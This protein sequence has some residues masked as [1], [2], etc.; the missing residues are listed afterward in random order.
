MPVDIIKIDGSFVRECTD[1][2][3]AAAFLAAIVELTHSL[4]LPAIAEAVETEAQAEAL[5]QVRCPLAQGYLFSRPVGAEDL[6]V[7]LSRT[8][9]RLDGTGHDQLAAIV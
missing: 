3:E 7:L 8:G 5:R 4:S 1:S 2:P 9:G 6:D